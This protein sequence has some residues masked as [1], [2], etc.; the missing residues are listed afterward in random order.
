M[1]QEGWPLDRAAFAQGHRDLGGD[2]T[3]GGHRMVATQVKR[4]LDA[5]RQAARLTRIFGPGLRQA[6]VMRAG[7]TA[8]A[9][10]GSAI[11]GV[12]PGRMRAL[13]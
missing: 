9:L 3:A 13:R 6:R 12:P 5:L 2:A 8:K 7:P 10:W 11:A 4:E 1:K